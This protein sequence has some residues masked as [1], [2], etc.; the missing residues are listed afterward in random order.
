MTELLLSPWAR[1]FERLLDAVDNS[2]VLCAPYV[3]SGPCELVAGRI[4]RRGGSA[5]V[6]VWVLTNL[7]RDNILSGATD[8]VSLL[9]L[10]EAIPR[11]T[12]RFL[13]SLHAK[14]YIADDKRAVITSS[15]FTDS[16]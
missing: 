7:S 4:G 5:S 9:R 6:D 8:V 15:N 13:P 10:A 16:G 2:L 11:T 12:I 1:E 14:V 3:G